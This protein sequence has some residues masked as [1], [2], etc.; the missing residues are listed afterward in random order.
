[1]MFTRS[2]SCLPVVFPE[3]RKEEHTSNTHNLFFHEYLTTD[4]SVP[5]FKCAAEENHTVLH[6]AALHSYGSTSVGPSASQH[7]MSL[8]WNHF[9]FS[10]AYAKL[11]SALLIPE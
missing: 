3:E 5:D 6:W 8:I 1:M 10:T 11:N 7:T 4:F 9:P 2:L